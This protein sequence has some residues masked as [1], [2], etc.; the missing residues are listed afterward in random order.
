M[1]SSRTSEDNFGGLAASSL[2]EQGEQLAGDL[3][4]SWQSLVARLE[5]QPWDQPLLNSVPNS[6][7][8]GSSAGT[9]LSRGVDLFSRT[10]GVVTNLII[11][12]FVGFYLAFEPDKYAKNLFRTSNRDVRFT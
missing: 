3:Q 9:I 11:I 5:R 12:L 2:I 7:Q 8:P 6:E 1:S 10:F 4:S